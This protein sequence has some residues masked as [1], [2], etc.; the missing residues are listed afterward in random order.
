MN[1]QVKEKTGTLANHGAGTLYVVATPIGNLQDITL[2]ALEVLR[3]VDHVV[4]EDTRHTRKLLSAHQIRVPLLSCHAH[5]SAEGLSRI[6]SLLKKGAQVA[7]VTDAG[8]PGISDPGVA[9]IQETLRHDLQ[10]IPIPGPCAA[11]AALIVSGLD[12]Q[13]FAFLGFPPSRGAHRTQFF[14]KYANLSMTRVLYES[15]RRLVRTLEDILDQWGDLRVAVARE[16]TKVHEEVFRGTV[17]QALDVYREGTRGEVT[18]VVEGAPVA[19]NG[20]V[21]QD[22]SWKHAL[23]A[24]LDHGDS[25]KNAVEKV[26]KIYRVRRRDAYQAAL[27]LS[28]RKNEEPGEGGFS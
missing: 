6:V 2:R 13:P 21:L 5:T 15:P 20:E 16:L 19:S 14:V 17:S 8:T 28:R 25:V 23:E 26:Q 11:I 9:L 7:L 24:Y 10:V 3:S 4:A 18:L 22:A 12:S 1:R 27:H